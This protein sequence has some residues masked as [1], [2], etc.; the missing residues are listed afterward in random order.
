MIEEMRVVMER[1]K[2]E[3]VKLAPLRQLVKEK[4]EEIN[5]LEERLA[6]G[7]RV[8]G[9]MMVEGERLRQEIEELRNMEVRLGDMEAEVNT[10]KRALR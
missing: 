2:E 5:V 4:E 1:H 10:L 7:R 3:Y 8:N 9:E 6:E